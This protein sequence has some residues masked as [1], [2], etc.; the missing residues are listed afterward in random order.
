MNIEDKF[1]SILASRVEGAEMAPD[2]AMWERIVSSLDSAASLSSLAEEKQLL[3]S[4][5][6]RRLVAVVATALG[7]AAVFVFSFL[8]FV[9]RASVE[10][11]T[12]SDEQLITLR[13]DDANTANEEPNGLLLTKGQTEKETVKNIAQAPVVPNRVV[14]NE[15]NVKKS[16][17]A[18]DA[19]SHDVITQDT[20][21][22]E[23]QVN[24]EENNIKRTINSSSASNTSSAYATLAMVGGE[25]KRAAKNTKLSFALR[26]SSGLLSSGVS[27]MEQGEA[28]AIYSL[29]ED[30]VVAYHG[31]ELAE[32]REWHHN[33][34]VSLALTMQYM[35]NSKWGLESGIMYTYMSSSSEGVNVLDGDLTK[36]MHYLGVPINI[37]YSLAKATN[38]NIYAKAGVLVDTPVQVEETRRYT[39]YTESYDVSSKGV[40]LSAQALLG[41]SYKLSTHWALYLEPSL[42]YYFTSNQTLSYRTHN[43][44]GYSA[45]AGL[46]FIL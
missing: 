32:E 26:G 31:A 17:L 1:K 11:V 13:E 25:E 46:R 2:D 18:Q 24:K 5:K 3:A 14:V 40:Q 41:V 35:I 20:V 21:A 19:V 36:K 27:S 42:S 43:K 23:S 39:S 22:Q 9:D 7:V 37:V 12:L 4:A 34:P 45:T 6:K 8:L 29:C 10:I 28:R 38:W 30:G 15:P 44:T 33:I 16:T